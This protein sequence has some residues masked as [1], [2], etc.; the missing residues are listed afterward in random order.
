MLLD[1]DHFLKQNGPEKYFV[2]A[3]ASIGQLGEA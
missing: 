3:V 2:D 1:I